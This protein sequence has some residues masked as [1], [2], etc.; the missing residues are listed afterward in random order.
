MPVK[1]EKVKSGDT[2][3]DRH[4]YKMGNTNLRSIGE[5]RVKVLSID[6]GSRTLIVTWNGNRPTTY[7]EHDLKGL[8]TWSMEDSDVEVTKGL[9]GRVTKVRK[10]TKKELAARPSP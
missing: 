3:Y 5:W 6:P 4:T 7:Y 1:F 10:L 9:W 2:L 8:Y